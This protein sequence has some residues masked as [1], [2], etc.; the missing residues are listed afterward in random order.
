[1]IKLTPFY[2]TDTS[3]LYHSY[4]NPRN[5]VLLQS[6]MDEEKKRYTCLT[7]IG[8]NTFLSK[9]TPEEILKLI[10]KHETEATF[11]FY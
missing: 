2:S 10:E 6:G 1:M 11:R 3:Y 4:I 5:L 7:F 8:G 9:E